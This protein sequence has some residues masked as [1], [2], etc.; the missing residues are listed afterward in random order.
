MGFAIRIE[1]FNKIKSAK[2]VK[3][4]KNSILS[5]LAKSVKLRANIYLAF[6]EFFGGFFV[7]IR[8]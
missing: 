6:K 3:F 5:A 8:H 4:S 7:S 2:R 1:F